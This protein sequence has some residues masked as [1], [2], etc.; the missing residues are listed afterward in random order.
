MSSRYDL[1]HLPP[2]KAKPV[3]MTPLYEKLSNWGMRSLRIEELWK[4]TKGEK[5][6]VCVLDTGANHKDISVKKFVNFTDD[7]DKDKAGHGTWVAGCIGA[8]GRFKG[9]APECELYIGKILANDG[10]GNWDWLRKGLEWALAEEC[11]IVNISAGGDYT[12]KEIQSVLRKMA[13][14]GVVIVAAAGNSQDLLIFPAN[15]RNTL[16]VGAVDKRWKKAVFSNWG[17]RLVVM[18][19]GVE[20][21]GP[22]LDDGYAK[23]TGTSMASPFSAGVLTLEQARHDLNLAEA[24]ARFA[25]TSKDISAPGWDPGTGWGVVAPHKFLQIEPTD[26]KITWAWIFNLAMF[27]MMY[28]VGDEENREKAKRVLF[29]RRK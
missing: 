21:L 28:F 19:P 6:R 22:W 29:G 27:I 26:K 8:N 12:G 23:C 7:E 15:D 16:A 25:W 5:V 17:P 18:A 13:D 2:Y 9:I 1:P 4:H 3:A 10:S 14:L 11:H 20:L 24:I